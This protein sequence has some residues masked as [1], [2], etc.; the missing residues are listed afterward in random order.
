MSARLFATAERR[1][2]QADVARE[3]DVDVE[4]QIVDVLDVGLTLRA[5]PGDRGQP[6]PKRNGPQPHVWIANVV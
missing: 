2:D 3:H 6:S 1:S 5:M 4:H